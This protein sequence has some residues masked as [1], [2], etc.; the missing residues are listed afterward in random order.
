MHGLRHTGIKD[1]PDGGETY[2]DLRKI[3][4]RSAYTPTMRILLTVLALA[5][6]LGK[7][8][9]S[10]PQ[11]G[12]SLETWPGYTSC[13]EASKYSENVIKLGVILPF[14]EK[15]PFSLPRTLPGIEYAV[16][17]VVKMGLL[18]GKTIEIERGDSQCSE[19]HGPLRAID[20]YLKRTANV[21]IGPACDYAV[22]PIAR[23][24]PYW[25]IPI[26]TGGALVTAFSEKK[27][28]YK[29]LTRMIG[30]YAKMGD[31]I[32]GFFREFKW[33]IPGLI[34]TES[35]QGAGKSNCYFILEAV[36]LALNKRFVAKYPER[37]MFT[38]GIKQDPDANNYE[39]ILKAAS[40]EC[41]SK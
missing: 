40:E 3:E 11:A 16:E 10:M 41:R 39:A 30:S 4:M 38:R 25:N 27:T 35:K 28:Q 34:Y 24:S 13:I 17:T 23:F 26:I 2:K 7:S 21:F 9:M 31:A 19:T 22:A 32:G 29:L 33:T 15:L 5:A 12:N 1:R 14:N 37:K 20:M 8:R 18:P 36:Y 6:M